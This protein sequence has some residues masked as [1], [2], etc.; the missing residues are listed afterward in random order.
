VHLEPRLVQRPEEPQAEDVVHVEVGQQDVDAA[1]IGGPAVHRPDARPGVE[2]ADGAGGGP[3]FDTGGVPAIAGGLRPGARQR[4]PHASQD[5]IH[6]RFTIRLGDRAVCRATDAATVT[7]ITQWTTHRR[8]TEW[9]ALPTVTAH[10]TFHAGA[11]I[12]SN[13]GVR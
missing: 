1:E 6:W 11:P 9:P 5:D 7:D 2:D 13:G 8:T 10:D 4:A 12:G 3:H